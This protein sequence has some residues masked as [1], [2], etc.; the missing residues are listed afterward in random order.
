MNLALTILAGAVCGGVAG[1][2]IARRLERDYREGW[3]K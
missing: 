2:L 1:V 3:G